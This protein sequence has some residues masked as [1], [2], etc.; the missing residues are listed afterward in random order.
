MNTSNAPQPPNIIFIFVDDLGWGD[1]QCY[2]NLFVKSPHLNRMAEEGTLFEQFYVGAPLCSPSRAGVITGQCPARHGIHYWM[3]PARWRTPPHN[4]SF[5]MPEYLDPAVVC[6]PRLMQQ[7][8]YRTA[9]FGKWHIG[10]EEPAPVVAYGYDETD[11]IWQ[12]VG[13]NPGVRP[14]D[15]RGTEMLVDRTIDFAGRCHEEGRPFFVNLWPRDVHAAL[16]PSQESLD[17]YK[18]LMSEGKFHTAMQIYYASITEMDLQIGRLLD[19][20]DAAPGL[21]ENT[22]VVFSSDNGPEDGY[23]THAAYH[24]AGLPGPFRGRKRSLYEGGIRMPFIVRW[25]GHV[26]AGRVDKASVLSALDL[27]PTFASLAGIELPEGYAPDGEDVSAALRGD[28]AHTRGKPLFWEWRFDGVG[29]CLN[30]S[31]MLAIRDGSWKLLFNPDRSRME[32]YDI[33]RQP[34]ELHSQAEKHPEIV[35][36]LA[37]LALA[38]QKQLPPGPA[39]DRPGSDE[40]PGYSENAQRGPRMDPAD[41][42]RLM[43]PVRVTVTREDVLY[44]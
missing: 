6:L 17:R 15:P 11:Y 42:A 8:G 30:R 16:K 7:G 39:T 23:I 26:P 2:G 41:Y 38:W 3:A 33:P 13:P 25:K 21:A 5:G 10:E 27:L 12:G 20:I 35:E 18:H 31:P 44:D 28:R 9:H 22:L 36:R 24:A 1:L 32:L 37:A 19:W 34:M 43:Q 29:Q 4:E 40:Y 14:D